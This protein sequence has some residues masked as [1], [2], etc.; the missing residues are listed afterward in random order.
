VSSYKY[1][2]L[3]EFVWLT[4]SHPSSHNIR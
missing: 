4:R 3:R 1:L 2:S